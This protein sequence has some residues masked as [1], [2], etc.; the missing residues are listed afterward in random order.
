MHRTG[1]IW[2]IIGYSLFLWVGFGLSH[3]FL[4]LAFHLDLPVL[5]AFFVL[6]AL[7]FGV[8]IPSA[9]GYIGT[10]HWACAA[11][12]IFLGVESNLA[13]S[14]SLLLWVAGFIPTILLGLFSLGKEG[15]SLRQIR[16]TEKE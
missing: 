9:P 11:A 6:V 14:F 13:K 8:S 12:L 10:F 16:E 7:T 2:V 3:Y 4:F 5:A 1:D 15:M